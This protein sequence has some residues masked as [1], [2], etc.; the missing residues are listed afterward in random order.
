MKNLADQNHR[1]LVAE[2]KRTLLQ[3][4]KQLDDPAIPSVEATT[5]P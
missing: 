2:L 5:K 1:K 4:M 3:G